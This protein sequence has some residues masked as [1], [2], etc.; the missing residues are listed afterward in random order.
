MKRISLIIISVLV[1]VI[2]LLAY[3]A[4]SYAGSY[5]VSFMGETLTMSPAEAKDG[6]SVTFTFR[7][8]NDGARISNVQIRVVEPC[9][10]RG[11]GTVL[12]DLTR[13]VINPGINTYRVTGTF[14]A[15]AGDKT[16]V[17]ISLLDRSGPALPAPVI[18]GSGYRQLEPASYKLGRYVPLI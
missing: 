12:R 16:G 14:R 13:Q 2:S 17:S 5:N 15:P 11:E 6:Q 1:G 7:V 4:L 10:S 18:T 3:L 8:K 9:N